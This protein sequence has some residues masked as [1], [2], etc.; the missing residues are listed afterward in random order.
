MNKLISKFDHFRLYKGTSSYIPLLLEY[1][2]KTDGPIIELG[3]GL[4]STPLLHWL[5]I[6][7]GRK[8]ITYESHAGYYEFA[9]KFKSPNHE[10]IFVK[11]WEDLIYPDHASVALI[12]HSPN[13][14]EKYR[15]RGHDI[16]KLKDKV[17]YF[18]LHDTEPEEYEHYKYN[19]VWPHFRYRRDWKL[20]LPYTSV[21]SN[22]KLL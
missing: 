13:S 3:S 6:E 8:L 9:K 22:K 17:D 7:G 16:L 4:F 2:R 14:V 18:I 1:V 21:I 10:V 19:L 11:D 12:D 5:C 15:Q 20:E